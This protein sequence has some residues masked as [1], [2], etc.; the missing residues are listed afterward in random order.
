MINGVP[1]FKSSLV[2][3]TSVDKKT[4]HAIRIL[5]FEVDGKILVHPDRWDEFQ[6]LT[7]ETEC[8]KDSR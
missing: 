4:G 1:V 5:Y 8:D 6:K 2:P 3:L 7:G